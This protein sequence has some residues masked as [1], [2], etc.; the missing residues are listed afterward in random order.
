MNNELKFYI[1]GS[2]IE[3]NSVEQIEVLNPATEE[4]LGNITAGTKEDV[5]IAV[6]AANNAFQTYSNFS[7]DQ[8]IAIFES[9]IKEYEAR[10]PEMAEVISDEMGAPM[11]LSNVAQAASGLG[12]FKTTLNYLKSFEFEKDDDGFT[13][14]KEPIGVVGMITPWNWPINQVSTK[15]ASALAAGCTMVLK[16]SEISP[17]CAMLL[18]EILDSSSL[19][20]GVFNLVNGYGPIVGAALSEHRSI[21]MMSF[22]GS[23]RAGIAVAQASAKNVKRV[24]QEL[25]GKSANIILDDANIEKAVAAGVSHCFLNSGQSC[26]APTRMLVSEKNYDLAVSVAKE[27]AEKT[28]VGDPKD[29][30][31][32][33]GPISNKTQYEKILRLIQI[34]ID[35][36][37]LL[38]T[39]GVERPEN[40]DKGY[41][42]KPTV[43]ANVT[44]DMTIAKEEIF[45][46]VICLIKYSSEEEAIEIANDTEYGLA[47]YVQGEISHATEVA[48]KIR[49]GQITINGGNRENAA[50]FGGYKM[51]GNGREHGRIGLEEFLETKAIIA[52]L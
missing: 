21:D 51:S 46:P 30:N 23:T 17:F 44:N 40:L 13:L 12:H 50:P 27:V 45:G 26:N 11:W 19:P 24:S 2:W 16:P 31:T 49:A 1:N 34:G 38:V 4:V 14:R 39:G 7:K 48:R 43:F 32:R 8:K 28:T 20:K 33:I 10:L 52:P 6:E 47:G 25:G 18:A 29:E 9:I 37:A 15:V 22:T 5:D 41:Y 3:P 35:E 42:V 36:G